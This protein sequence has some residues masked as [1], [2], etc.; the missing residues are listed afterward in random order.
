MPEMIK[1]IPAKGLKV[2]MPDKPTEFLPE[3]GGEVPKDSYWLRRVKD[4]S[5]QLDEPKAAKSTTEKK[6]S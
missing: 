2:R 4:G 5:V 3:K 1:V 6:E